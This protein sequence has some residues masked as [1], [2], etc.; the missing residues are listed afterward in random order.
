MEKN[1][2]S[3]LAL[4]FLAWLAIMLPYASAINIE[5]QQ[6]IEKGKTLKIIGNANF[7]KVTIKI[8]FSGSTVKETELETESDGNFSFDYNVAF[9][10]PSGTWRI[11]AIQGEDRNTAFS[12]IKNSNESAF[13][14]IKFFSPSKQNFTATENIF[15][16]VRITDSGKLVER[17]VTYAWFP[18]LGKTPL[19][20]SEKGVY[21]GELQIPAILQ[22]G[23]YNVIVTSEKVSSKEEKA[24]GENVL[25]ISIAKPELIITLLKPTLYEAKIAK[26]IEIVAVP[27]YSTGIVPE[28]AQ[29]T[30]EIN[31]KKI[32]LEKT[33]EGFS[34]TYVPS[35]QDG[36]LLNIKIIG[37]DSF[38]N[39]GK[40]EFS[41]K[42]TGFEENFLEKNWL[43]FI[44]CIALAIAA[45]AAG[46]WFFRNRNATRQTEQK[47]KEIE[48]KM[49]K[50][51]ESF[52]KR[53]T[54]DR[55][56]FDE[57]LSKY[58]ED[59]NDLKGKE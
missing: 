49:K 18:Q 40:K 13:L 27:S 10:D 15:F 11:I 34:A 17:A 48:T 19:Q 38:G 22:G 45:I 2:S 21:S 25:Q 26:P 9:N 33:A 31:G 30:A 12:R 56:T 52:Y 7:G 54:V 20:E 41:M 50:V 55:K 8:L 57:V 1:S 24:G 47:K 14:F 4:A 16:S 3:F 53:P 46:A 36:S 28:E 23:D 44:I 59:L 6:N 37:Y 39:S 5:A 29:I 35:E 32:N 51:E 42:I 43:F 58:R